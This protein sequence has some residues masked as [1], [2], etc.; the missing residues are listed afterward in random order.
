MYG[1]TYNFREEDATDGISFEPS[2]PVEVSVNSLLLK[3]H[4]VQYMRVRKCTN[5]IKR[6]KPHYK[7]IAYKTIAYPSNKGLSMATRR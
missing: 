6:G 7:N 5:T 2:D 3:H 1:T 4:K